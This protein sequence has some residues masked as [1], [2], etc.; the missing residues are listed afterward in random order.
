MNFKEFN[1]LSHQEAYQAFE[2]CCVSTS[3]INEMIKNMPFNSK[4]ELIEKA[5]SFWYSHCTKKDWEEAFTGHP[6]IGDVDSLKKRFSNTKNWANNEQSNVAGADE[7]TLLEL[8]NLNSKYLSKFGYIFIVSASGKSAHEILTILK[9]RVLNSFEEEIQVAMGEQHKI[10]IIR[11]LKLVD[12][13]SEQTDLRSHI[14]THVLDT[15][16]G[17]PAKGMPIIL[18]GKT[19]DLYKP[20]TIGVTNN[21]GRIADLLPPGKTLNPGTYQMVFHT[22]DYYKEQ[23]QNGFY[24]QVKIQFLVS[25]HDHYHVPLLINPFGYTT[26]KGS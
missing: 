5:A 2:K 15:S 1:N 22:A 8:S 7:E 26:Y 25:D 20:L 17:I 9:I 12:D 13:L 14:T 6:K 4:D 18:E 21:D 16:T 24:P 10:T 19:E 23:E 11:L 3:W